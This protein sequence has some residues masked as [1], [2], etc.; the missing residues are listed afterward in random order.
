MRV[1]CTECPAKAVIRS[2]KQLDVKVAQLYCSCTD[3][4]CGHTFVM[5]LSFSHTLSPS[6]NQT[7]QMLLDMFRNMPDD[8]RQEILAAV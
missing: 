3:P 7:K 5:D 4:I 8:E 1:N 2:R 6:G